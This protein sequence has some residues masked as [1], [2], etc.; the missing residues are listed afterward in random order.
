MGLAMLFAG[1][2]IAPV[3][4]MLSA[5]LWLV[6]FTLYVL[7]LVFFLTDRMLKR[8]AENGKEGDGGEVSYGPAL[9]SDI[10]NYTGW[11]DGG[12]SSTM[13]DHSGDGLA[14]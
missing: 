10:H 7:G 6:A 4:W 8:A 11:R 12:R 1:P 2:V 14:D 13:N 3:A 5:R 9:P